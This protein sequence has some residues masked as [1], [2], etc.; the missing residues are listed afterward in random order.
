MAV[1]GWGKPRIFIKDLDATAPK[2]EG[3]P[4]PVED[5]TQLETTK[6]DKQEAKIEGGENEDVKYGKNTYALTFNLR[7]IKSRKRPIS[8][9]DGVVAHN[10]AVAVQPE[11]ADVQ[12]FCMKK[13]AVSVED[14]FS[15]SDGGVWAYTFDALK[16]SSTDKQVYWGKI[17]VT[18]ASGAISKIECDPEDDSG[19]TDKFEV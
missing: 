5:S 16:A 8:D 14:S 11:D 7:A 13:S 2:W 12:G 6:G 19:S 4:T 1:V 3:L 18:E 17:I 10:Y 15:T 9:D